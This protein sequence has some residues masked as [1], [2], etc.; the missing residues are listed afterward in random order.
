MQAKIS[1]K[2]SV[3]I[4]FICA[5]FMSIMD[6]TIVNVA[7]PAIGRQFG[8]AGTAV[9]II[10]VSYLVSLAVIIPASGWLGD[11][12]GTKRVFLSALALFT[13]ASALCG[14]AN[15]LGLLVLFRVLQ[16]LA[17]GALT[18]VGN[19]MLIRT[20]PPAERVQVSRI[21]SIPTV[22][23]PATGPVLGGLLV[24]KLSWHWVFYV[25][26][27]I[28]LLAFIF[29][30]LFLIEL[31]DTAKPSFDIPGFFLAG[32]GLGMTMYAMSEGP[33]YGWTNPLILITLIAGLLLV[34]T[35]TIIE[36]RVAE[37]LINLRLLKNG[38]FRNSNI[39][40][41]L[42]TAAFLGILYTAPL[43]LQEARGVSA[44]TSGLTTFPE[45][46]GVIV[47]IQIGARI[48][49]RI[50]PRRMM[51]SGIVSAAIMMALLCVMGTTTSLWIMR[52]LML[53]VGLSMSQ[54]FLSTQT[55]AFATITTNEAGAASAFY[56][57]QRQ[58]GSAIGVAILSTVI[59]AV[60]PTQRTATG[61]IQPNLTAYHAAFITAAILALTAFAFALLISDKDAAVT[62]RRPEARAKQQRKSKQT[63][64]SE[65]S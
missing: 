22:L 61:A 2:V 55:A 34:A 19:T 9:D 35:F 65:L 57:T 48:Y 25:N 36:L 16:G 56:N 60:G 42:T 17:G 53:L 28:G 27:P 58:I 44:L 38:L 37:P 50:G 4:V 63:L 26:V 1:P 23:A 30:L 59:S 62:M 32:V 3:S 8:M 49:W 51:A 10:V 45:A 5:M 18:P 40:I 52:G 13:L 29:G 24:D 21:L 47:G 7:L 41:V 6:G 31:N 20:F 46:V 33:N 14:L 15:S 39:V 12:L 64:S 43:F 11:R 54:I